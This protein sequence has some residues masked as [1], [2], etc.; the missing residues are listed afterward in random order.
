[1]S[2]FAILMPALH[3]QLPKSGEDLQN[4]VR[5]VFNWSAGHLVLSPPGWD[6][7]SVL[8]NTHNFVHVLE[9]R[10]RRN[11][12]RLSINLPEIDVLTYQIV[13]RECIVL[14]TL[15]THT[16][17]GSLPHHK[18]EAVYVDPSEVLED[19]HVH[20]HVQNLR[21]HVPLCADP[22]VLRDVSFPGGL[23]VGHG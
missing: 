8:I 6:L 14:Y 19:G 22:R 17:S 11:L 1:M 10:V 20:G 9:P 3:H 13:I 12:K 7:R 21:G 5:S 18:P 4:R 16:P 2:D 15:V 23:C